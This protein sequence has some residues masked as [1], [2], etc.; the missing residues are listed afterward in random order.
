MD[1]STRK[2][3][4]CGPTRRPA[5][6]VSPSAAFGG[7]FNQ[8]SLNDAGKVAFNSGGIWSNAS[9][10][11]ELIALSKAPLPPQTLD[12]TFEGFRNLNLDNAGNVE[13]VSTTK[14][15]DTVAWRGDAAGLTML[16]STSAQAPGVAPGSY[17]WW[18][19]SLQLTAN[20]SGNVLFSAT[21]SN[22]PSHSFSTTDSGFWS[23]RSGA[24]L[25]VFLRSTPSPTTTPGLNCKVDFFSSIP[26]L[27]NRDGDFAIVATL[28]GSGVTTTNDSAL[29]VYR[30]RLATML[31]REGDGAPGTEAGVLF[32]GLF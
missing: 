31:A 10:S 25:P 12:T 13:F 11:L 3:V 21:L 23:D 30:A 19:D 9:G 2:R 18:R 6:G 28:F 24:L 26:E 8:F 4:A 17:F 27:I 29:V 5:P 32:R 7:S 16:A 20:K 15:I 1:G 22:T 14:T